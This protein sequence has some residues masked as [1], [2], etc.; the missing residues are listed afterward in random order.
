MPP[1]RA[2]PRPCGEHSSS[3]SLPITPSGSSP[4]VRGARHPDRQLL[5]PRGLIPARAGSTVG[6]CGQGCG[7]WAH[8]RPCGEHE[9]IWAV[10]GV[11]TGSSPPVR[12]ALEALEPDIPC[13]GLIPARA[14][15]THGIMGTTTRSRAH[16][17]PCGEHSALSRPDSR[18]Q[19]SSPPVRGAPTAAEPPAH[20][21]GLIPARAGSTQPPHRPSAWPRA[22]PRPC[23]E[24]VVFKAILPIV[25]GSSPP[26][27]GAPEVQFT[28]PS[29]TGL[30][31][32]RAGSTYPFSISP[33]ASGAHPRPCGEH[34]LTSHGGRM[35]LGSSP[36]VRGAHLLTWGFIPY[37]GK[38]GLLWS[39]SLRPEYTINNCS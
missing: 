18:G 30:I 24:H 16:P 36:P 37:T 6:R 25:S 29:R 38:I 31:P 23:G 10:T 9:R 11:D 4:P 33:I 19:G 8:P 22:H 20:V 35:H 2:H 32:A 27:R 26:V 12:G 14:G 39:Q 13:S 15:S 7:A 5:Q 1:E 21:P 28:F 34:R 17:R 3:L